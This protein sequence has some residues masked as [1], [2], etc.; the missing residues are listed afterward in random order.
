MCTA[1][2]VFIHWAAYF[3]PTSFQEQETLTQLLPALAD[4][5]WFDGLKTEPYQAFIGQHSQA[6]LV[7]AKVTLKI[8]NMSYRSSRWFA[9]Y[10]SVLFVYHGENQIMGSIY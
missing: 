8:W 9:L 7:F 1:R 2:L 5:S 6:H 4:T 10:K 3:G